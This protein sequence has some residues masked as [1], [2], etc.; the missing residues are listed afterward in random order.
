MFVYDRCNGNKQEVVLDQVSRKKYILKILNDKNFL[1]VQEVVDRFGVSPMT[2]RRD[3]SELEK[4]G[5]LI[6]K[7]GGAVKSE[8]VD[9]MFSFKK[10]VESNSGQKEK[11]CEIASRFIEDNDIIFVD[12]GTTLFRLSHYIIR[13][14]RLRVITNSLPVVSELINYPNIKITFIGGD[15]VSDRKAS[16]GSTA[17]R[18]IS[19]YHADKAFIG[20]DGISLKNGLSSYDE[21]EG[22]ITRKMAANADKVFLLC[23]SSKIERDSFCRFSPVSIIDV[24]ITEKKTSEEDVS[25]YLENNITIINQ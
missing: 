15:I 12:C 4:K 1:S 16:Y 8:A 10:R 25:R 24:L 17:E 22:L 7:Y 11:I 21:K 5:Y 9:N 23:D 2:I 3:L 14:N 6:R 13:K 18:L 20:A 19:E